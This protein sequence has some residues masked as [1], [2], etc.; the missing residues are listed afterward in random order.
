M[1]LKYLPIFITN[2]LPLLSQTKFYLAFPVVLVSLAIIV[3]IVEADNSC[4][5]DVVK[6]HAFHACDYFSDQLHD[7]H[8]RM[9]TRQSRS[10]RHATEVNEKLAANLPT[11]ETVHRKY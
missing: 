9:T 2:M 4:Q 1:S 8:Y 11:T 5:M 6:M 10:R 7:D 3:Q